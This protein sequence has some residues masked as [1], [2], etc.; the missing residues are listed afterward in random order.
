ML[1]SLAEA[2]WPRFKLLV[3]LIVLFVVIQP[4]ANMDEPWY[5]IHAAITIYIRMYVL[6]RLF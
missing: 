4:L 1:K 6:G 2:L 5:Y 3:A